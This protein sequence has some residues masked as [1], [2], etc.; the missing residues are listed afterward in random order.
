MLRVGLIGN[1][2]IARHHRRVYEALEAEGTVRLE[3]ICD[4]HPEQLE[5]MEGF[6][7]YTDYR[8][9][10]QQEQGRL[11]YI[12]ICVPT[13]FHAEIA[14][15]AMELGFHVLC[16]KPMARTV[17]Q[18][19]AMLDASKRTGMTLMIAHCCRFM[20]EAEVVRDLIESGELGKVRSAMFCRTG[21][22]LGPLGRDNWY[23]NG[24]ISGGAMMDLHSHDTDLIRGLFGMPK[25]VSTLA[26]GDIKTKGG[27]DAMSTNYAFEDGS[28][29]HVNCDW[30]TIK[31]RF[32]VRTIRVNFEKGYVY[33][34]R[35][36]K[37]DALMIVREDGTTTD[38]VERLNGHGSYQK[39]IAYFA[40]C[41]E[42]GAPVDRCP[43]E[44]ALD[45]IRLIFAEKESADK[46]GS[47]VTL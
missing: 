25:A 4:I 43:P 7:T 2:G 47:L 10:L 13:V 23:Y 16:E 18:A 29:V 22:D 12:D 36:T 8:Q 24:E 32:N 30:T 17:E 44:E 15:K 9:L 3:A 28:F 39:E 21:G 6:R 11:D 33:A 37:R 14:V 41:L 5:Q 40:R 42:T 46:G 27:Y 19:Q 26:L 34:D 31:D 20:G 38:L 1:G 35:Y 45:A